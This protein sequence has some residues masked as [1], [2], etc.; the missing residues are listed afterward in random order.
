MKANFHS[1]MENANL[2]MKDFNLLDSSR[3]SQVVN[4][5]GDYSQV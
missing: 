1:S 2:K 5:K 3:Y 4:T